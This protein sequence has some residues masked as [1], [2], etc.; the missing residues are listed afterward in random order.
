MQVMYYGIEFVKGSIPT[1]FRRLSIRIFTHH[2]YMPTCLH[3]YLPTHPPTYIHTSIH[4]CI[5]HI[6]LHYI[7]LH[8]TT[9]HYITLHTRPSMNKWMRSQ[10]LA[11]NP[12]YMPIYK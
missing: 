12:I 10:L 4:A 1:P 3:T 5:H 11:I 9:L 2:A 7:T 6:T 8:Y